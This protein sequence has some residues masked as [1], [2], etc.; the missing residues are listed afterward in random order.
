MTRILASLATMTFLCG[1]PLLAQE[2]ETPAP[3]TDSKR[4]TP[5]EKAATGVQWTTDFA[6]AK[7]LAAKEKKKWAGV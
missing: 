3:K 2:L 7:A 1:A 4:V 6:A 5:D